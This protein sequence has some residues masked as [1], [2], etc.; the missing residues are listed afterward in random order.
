MFPGKGWFSKACVL[1]LSALLA[2]FL[3]W[4]YLRTVAF[5][6]GPPY[7]D[8]YA[9]TWSYQLLMGAL[10]LACLLAA[11]SV[12]LILE[13]SFFKLYR[14]VRIRGRRSGRA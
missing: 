12:V 14:I 1:Q 9:Q 2:W 4:Y 7:G 5:L 3:P 8:L 13:A 6:A 10:W 11:L